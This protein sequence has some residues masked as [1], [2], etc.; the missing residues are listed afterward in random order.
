MDLIETARSNG[1]YFWSVCV[2]FGVIC[3]ASKVRDDFVPLASLT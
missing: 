2:Q 3:A 1:R